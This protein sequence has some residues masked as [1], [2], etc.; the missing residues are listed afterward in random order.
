[1]GGKSWGM[2]VGGSRG[3]GR[4]KTGRLQLN[5]REIE[6]GTMGISCAASEGREGRLKVYQDSPRGAL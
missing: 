6:K 5:N 3:R 1:M 2:C 4:K